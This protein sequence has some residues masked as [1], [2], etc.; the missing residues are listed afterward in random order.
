MCAVPAP[1]SRNM[2][3]QNSCLCSRPDTIIMEVDENVPPDRVGLTVALLNDISYNIKDLRSFNSYNE[4][5]SAYSEDVISQDLE[6]IGMAMEEDITMTK[7]NN[8]SEFVNNTDDY[9]DENIDEDIE[10]PHYGNRHMIL[11]EEVTM[12]EENIVEECVEHINEET[13]ANIDVNIDEQYF[14]DH[15]N[16]FE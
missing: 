10:E 3:T 14:G 1:P 8:D 2:V 12:R 5:A 16:H 15:K 7:E 11:N 13:N 9:T 4:D 6:L